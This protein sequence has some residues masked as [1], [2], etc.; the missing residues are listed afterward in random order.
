MRAREL[1]GKAGFAYSGPDF[2]VSEIIFDSRKAGPGK[3]FV[4][5]RG[6]H[7]DGHKFIDN[8]IGAGSEVAVSEEIGMSR[9]VVPDTK[10]ALANLSHAFYGY[11]SRSLKLCG[12]TATNGKTTTTHMIAQLLRGV[13]PK[14]GL[15]GTA[16]HYLPTGRIQ[17]DISNPTTTPYPTIIDEYLSGMKGAGSKY[18]VL[19]L[20]SFGLECGR[21]IGLEFDTIGIGN[22]THCHHALL[23]GTH[24][25][26]VKI[27]ID[28][29]DLLKPEGI[30]VLNIEDQYYQDALSKVEGKKIITFGAKKGDI[31][32]AGFKPTLKGSEVMASIFG[33]TH[34]YR[35]NVPSVAN[36]LNSLCAIG[37]AEAVGV[38]SA[39]LLGLLEQMPE[40]PGRWNWIDECQPFAVAVDKAN[41]PAALETVVEHMESVRP[42]RK[43]IITNNV[44]EGDPKAR[45][46]LAEIASRTCDLTIITY[47]VAKGEDIDS[48]VNQFASFMEK[49]GGK[50]KIIKDRTE[51]IHWAINQ[52]QEGDFIAILG[53]GDEDGMYIRG[54]WFEVDD[55]V[56]AKKALKA[57]GFGCN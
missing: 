25:N 6:S 46:K 4:A 10:T 54:Q 36:A 15:V 12:V 56:E 37:I 55:R 40:I 9:I 57:R 50:Y 23:H 30:A 43:I 47:G 33:K 3:V 7:T 8:A 5:L 45:E 26:Y 53:R 42:K 19:E 39:P 16:G 27:K 22:I 35:L 34:T 21:V 24:E 1:F 14:V 29:L 49:H 11:P 18:A 28:S 51:A 13:D 48:T 2:E 20:S 38:Q 44:G 31:H 17:P 52:A 41:T 32:I